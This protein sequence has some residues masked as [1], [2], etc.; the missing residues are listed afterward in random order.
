MEAPIRLMVSLDLSVRVPL[1]HKF[2]MVGAIDRDDAGFPLALARL[3]CRD[4]VCARGREYDCAGAGP[5]R[6]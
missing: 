2:P 4:V 6:L 3:I 1:F 5:S